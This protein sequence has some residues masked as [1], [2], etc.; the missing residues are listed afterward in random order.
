MLSTKYALLTYTK[1]TKLQTRK[2]EEQIFSFK[3]NIKNDQRR[4]IYTEEKHFP[5]SS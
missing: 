3:Q 4:Q 5:F 2:K 1:E